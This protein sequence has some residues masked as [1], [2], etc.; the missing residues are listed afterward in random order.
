MAQLTITIPDAKVDA[1][2][3]ALSERFGYKETIGG[4]PNPQS[5]ASFVKEKLINYL[6][7]NYREHMGYVAMQTHVGDLDDLS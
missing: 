4:E 6:K 1:V 7:S 2:L 3:N 5:K